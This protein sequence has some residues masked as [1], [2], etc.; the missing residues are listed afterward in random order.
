MQALK[1]TITSRSESGSVHATL[2]IDGN[3]TGALY[4]TSAELKD[5]TEILSGGVNS[6]ETPALFTVED[7]FDCN[8]EIDDDPWDD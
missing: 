1:L 6:S 5:L 7:S 2:E 3:N 8:Q 4:L